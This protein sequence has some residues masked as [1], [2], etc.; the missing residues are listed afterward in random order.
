MEGEEFVV[1]VAMVDVSEIASLYK[2]NILIFGWFVGLG[3]M[4]RK[5]PPAQ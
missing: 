5:I 4:T 2:K 3:F 1:V